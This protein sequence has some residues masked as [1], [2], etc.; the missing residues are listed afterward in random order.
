MLGFSVLFK[1]IAGELGLSRA[2]ASI[3][4][5]L[6]SVGQGIWAPA[7]G[8]ASD[9]YGP[10]GIILLGIFCLTLGCI[11][12]YFVSSLWAF[13]VVWGLIMGAGF[14]L[15]CMIVTDKAIINWFIKKSGIAINLKFALVGLSGLLLLPL[16][17]WLIT[18]QGWR[19]TCLIFGIV[20]ALVGFPIVWFFVKPHPP[21]YYGLLPDGETRKEA[22]AD[23]NLI[24]DKATNNADEEMAGFTLKQTLKTPAFWVMNA[25]SYI[26]GLVMPIMGVHCIPFLTDMGINPVKASAMMGFMTTV[27]IPVRL[28]IGPIIDRM[29]TDHLRF[30]MT[31]GYTLQAIGVTA[32]LLNKSEAM[33]YVWFLLAGIG[34]AI[35]FGVQLPMV[36][37]YFG[38]K[39]FGS[40]L[41]LWSTI[42]VPIGLIAP[43]YV[44]W[45]YDTTGSYMSAITLLAPLLA[46]SGIVACFVLP[47]K[48][49]ALATPAFKVI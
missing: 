2:V 1:P 5:S 11:L 12:M 34:G 30:I 3:A 43:V 6:Q 19:V 38:R 28:V 23:A 15:G 20:I 32:F 17:A 49:P 40:I 45:V 9:R 8:W 10:R 44:G 24:I 7:G 35:S 21:E 41:G 36:A 13:L 14:T 25:V 46:A 37:R 22:A 26:A 31:V 33:I 29:K 18:N 39:A 42:N 27:S 48:P 16:I 4:S 47:P